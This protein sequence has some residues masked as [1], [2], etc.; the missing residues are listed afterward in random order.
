MQ[1]LLALAFSR[2]KTAALEVVSK[3]ITET[4]VNKNSVKESSSTY[5]PSRQT[6]DSTVSSNRGNIEEI[7]NCLRKSSNRS[8]QDLSKKLYPSTE[9]MP[10]QPR[11]S[12]AS[13]LLNRDTFRS[14]NYP[15]GSNDQKRTKGITLETSSISLEVITRLEIMKLSYLIETLFQIIARETLLTLL[16]SLEVVMVPLAKIE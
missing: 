15:G 2:G 12:E 14:N 13:L 8:F 1:K 10:N 11:S 3:N 9:T 16:T 6:E 7:M 4:V 5:L